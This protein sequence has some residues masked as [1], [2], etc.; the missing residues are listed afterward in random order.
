MELTFTYLVPAKI[1]AFYLCLWMDMLTFNDE[2]DKGLVE[3]LT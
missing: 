3:M 2:L 1:N